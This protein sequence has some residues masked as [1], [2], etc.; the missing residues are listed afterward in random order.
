M[1][2][3]KKIELFK[4][5]AKTIKIS[6]QKKNKRSFTIY[7]IEIS[8]E[9]K[10]WTISK[11]FND[12]FELDKIIK[13]KYS[14]LNLVKLS[15]PKLFKFSNEVI[16]ERKKNFENYLNS[17]FSSDFFFYEE[18]INF[19]NLDKNLLKLFIIKSFLFNKNIQNLEFF[20][21]NL[22]FSNEN[23]FYY[24][25]YSFLNDKNDEEKIFITIKE[26]LSNLK[27]MK[28]YSVINIKEF[29]NFLL[30]NRIILSEK[31]VEFL[32]VGNKNLKGIL[33]YISKCKK[34]NEIISLEFLNFLFDLSN[35]EKNIEF[36]KFINF[37]K[38]FRID[39]FKKLNLENFIEINSQKIFEFLYKLNIDDLVIRKIICIHDNYYEYLNFK[40]KINLDNSLF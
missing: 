16:N 14:N 1:S 36:E 2:E 7:E 12:F 18:I 37:F 38:T 33:Y 15:S 32:L 31:N 40:E 13:L 9:F 21:R 39:L 17:I 23:N 34:E 6:N 5:N 20:I 30:K 10:K 3:N 8:T 26:F 29:K 28:N 11:R 25:I 22:N 27:N 4:I 35:N 19:I 24:E